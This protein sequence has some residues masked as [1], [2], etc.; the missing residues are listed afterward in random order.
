MILTKDNDFSYRENNAC[1]IAAVSVIGDRK[2]QEDCF[3]YKIENQSLLLCVCDGMGGHKGG[4]AASKTA[5]ETILQEYNDRTDIKDPISTLGK[6]TAKA[7]EAVS[8]LHETNEATSDAG[9]TLVLVY[10]ADNQLYWSSVGDSRLYI[11]RKEEFIQI[12]KDQNYHTVLKEKSNAGEISEEE[13][14][15]GQEKG[16]ALVNYLGI[17]VL[18]LV[19]YNKEPLKLKSG[20]QIVICTDGL[21]RILTDEEIMSVLNAGNDVKTSLQMMEFSARKKAGENNKRRDNMTVF[22]IKIK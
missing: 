21:Y 7:N 6:F 18:N 4:R 2:A 10:V 12:T 5:V 22:L 3:G 15:Q 11:W 17:G 1:E 8:L 14:L 20:D 16:D 9:S 13:F 19:D